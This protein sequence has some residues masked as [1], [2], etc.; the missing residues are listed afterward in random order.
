M[1]F[2]HAFPLPLV[3]DPRKYL[4]DA[5]KS[6]CVFS[7]RTFRISG[8][9]FKPLMHLKLMFVCG[10]RLQYSFILLNVAVQFS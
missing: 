10:V 3:S 8:L 7:S 4:Q 5:M 6:L 9:R 1:C 2:L